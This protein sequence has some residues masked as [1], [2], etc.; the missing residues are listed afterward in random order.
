[1]F[2]RAAG[3]RLDAANV[4]LAHAYHLEAMYLAG[5]CA[6]CSLK[7][8]ILARTPRSK[9]ADE[10]DEVTHGS[11]A[12]N[13]D[14]LHARLSARRVT[15]SKEALEAFRRLRTWSTDFRYETRMKTFREASLF[16]RMAGVMRMWVQR[17]M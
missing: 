3:Q 14:F 12:H 7:A 10:L 13:L 6:E 17:S 15:F 1:M 2:M 11:I 9:L 5:Y 16:V 8:L 4:L